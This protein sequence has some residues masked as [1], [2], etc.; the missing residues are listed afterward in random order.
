[1]N[2]KPALLKRLA[3]RRAQALAAA[4]VLTLGAA[5]VAVTASNAQSP[6]P[7]PTPS[8][9]PASPRPSA[10]P[11][12]DRTQAMNDHLNRLAQNL[13][14]TV[15]RLRA[16]MQQTALQEVDAAVAAGRLTA[17]QAQEI[18]ARIN[19]G[20]VGGFGFG[21]GG[22]GG[23]HGGRGPGASLDALAQFL[24]TT[25]DTLRTELNG[26]S[27]AQVAQTH[28]RTRDQLIQFL[29]TAEQQHLAQEIQSGRITQAQADQ[30]LADFR[31]RVA[32]KV[33][34]VRTPGQ[35]PTMPGASP[36]PSAS[37]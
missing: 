2:G 6:S 4:G 8:T 11:S 10:S 5:G 35:R 29:V 16:A 32:Q 34:E 30:R 3:G 27:L 18:K 24:G 15:D 20:E 17:Q 19:A 26:R 25:A 12:A 21:F 28:N 1:M 7:S 23:D 37:P 14:I 33:D 13:G 31:T 36:R 22:R 9:A